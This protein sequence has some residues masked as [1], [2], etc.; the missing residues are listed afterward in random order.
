MVV[1]LL[2]VS[3]LIPANLVMAAT[4]TSSTT[5]SSQAQP[6]QTTG[7]GCTHNI[8][9]GNFGLMW[10]LGLAGMGGMLGGCR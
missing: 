3:L 6:S 5:S 8:C 9:G 4:S 10:F 2:T 7:G 1:G